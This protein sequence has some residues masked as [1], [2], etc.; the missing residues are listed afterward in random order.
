MLFNREKKKNILLDLDGTLIN[1][2]DS[3]LR[4]LESALQE[5]SF[6]IQS[7]LSKTIIGPPINEI[8]NSLLPEASDKIIALVKNSFFDIYD[9][10]N[11][12]DCQIYE[13]AIEFL[14]NMQAL[15]RDIFLVTNKRERPTKEILLKHG[16]NKYFKNIYSI[17]SVYKRS[18][19]SKANLLSYIKERES[20]NY[21]ESIYIGDTAGD[22]VACTRNRLDFIFAEWGYGSSVNLD[23]LKA[24][25]FFEI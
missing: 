10:K 7:G 14:N 8:I 5:N 15:D 13:G 21:Y 2:A 24:S 11:C 23:C 6:Q 17:D 4:S 12:V 3:V 9:K 20:L 16:L 1:S 22:Y 19:K 18:I 25:S